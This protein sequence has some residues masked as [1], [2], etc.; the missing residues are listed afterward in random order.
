MIAHV[1]ATCLPPPHHSWDHERTCDS[2]PRSILA[3]L[4]RGAFPTD[5]DYV[6][7]QAPSPPACATSR[8]LHTAL[9][10]CTGELATIAA[11]A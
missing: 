3:E 8:D 9:L 1:S 5:V 10:A 11:R 7:I 6:L 4:E 2:A